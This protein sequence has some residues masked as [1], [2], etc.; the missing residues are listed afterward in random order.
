MKR[1]YMTYGF[2]QHIFKIT[3]VVLL[4]AFNLMI[5]STNNTNASP[6]GEI[7]IDVNSAS[8]STDTGNGYSF[9]SSSGVLHFDE[10][11]ANMH[12]IIK[13]TNASVGPVLSIEFTEGYSPASVTIVGLLLSKGIN[14]PSDFSAD[15]SFQKYND[16]VVDLLNN[17]LTLPDGYNGKLDINGLKVASLKLPSDYSLPLTF[18]NLTVLNTL[19]YPNNYNEPI[20]IGGTFIVPQ[21]QQFP[22]NYSGAVTIGNTDGVFT[23]THVI[24]RPGTNVSPHNGIYIPNAISTITMKN[25]KN[26]N[27]SLRWLLAA[28][29]DVTLLLDGSSVI[30]GYIE[31]PTTAKITIDSASS[32]GT[33]SEIGEL[34]ITTDSSNACIGGN[35]QWDSGLIVIKGGTISAR[36]T[37]TAVGSYAAAIGGGSGKA[38]NVL[39]EGGNITAKANDY[40]AAIGGG[41]GTEGIGNVTITGGTIKATAGTN[42]AAIGGGNNANG[43]LKKSTGGII[44]ISGGTIIASGGDIALITIGNVGG[45]GAGIGSGRNGFADIYIS[46]GNVTANSGHGAGI[47]SGSNGNGTVKGFISITGGVIRGYSGDGANIGAGLNNGYIPVYKINK[48][49]DILMYGRSLN[50]NDPGSIMCNGNN[51]GDGYFVNCFN[52]QQQIRGDIYV[53]NVDT[54]LLQKVLHISYADTNYMSFL[55]S[56]GHDYPEN[57]HIYTDYYGNA[58]T[59]K[60]G[61][62]RQYTHHYD[63]K[64]PQPGPSM[65]QDNEPVI[66]SVTHMKSYPHNFHNTFSN[67]LIVCFGDDTG[68]GGTVLYKIKEKYVD[69]NG[70]PIPG[71]SDNFSIV[72]A[73]EPYTNSIPVIDGYSILGYYIGDPYTGTYIAGNTV[74]VESL[75]DDI[76]IYYVYRLR[77]KTSLQISKLVTGDYANRNK[78]FTFKVVIKDSD[79]SWLTPGITFEYIGETLPD[80]T[81]QAPD[82]GTVTIGNEGEFEISL[83]HGQSIVIDSI[84][85]DYTIQIIEDEDIRYLVTYEDNILGTGSS[86]DTGEWEM[87]D[88]YRSVI[89]INERRY[90]PETGLDLSNTDAILLLPIMILVMLY[91]T[92]TLKKYLF[93]KYFNHNT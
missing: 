57:F 61:G 79:G 48:E 68:G 62:M 41:D 80:I 42:G 58:P 71:K 39:I 21:S 64:P 1:L 6:A 82:N 46:G 73:H 78:E 36:Q 45:Y 72:K 24:C 83:K 59:Y 10:D 29:D 27:G 85:E 3:L 31:V 30:N 13:R 76:T 23:G 81:T 2:L 84:T 54:S 16:S 5:L 75:E 15:L 51:Q 92:I 65:H 8:L 32:P 12:Y 53:Y 67:G 90:V 47:G 38:G 70:N 26:L 60:Y 93:R 91:L 49:A 86:R 89:F 9:I 43:G 87:T 88:S 7:I 20:T 63:H 33:N 17:S 14:I 40:G 34:S 28:T 22:A 4:L 52:Y 77:Q 50:V 18:N 19:S 25:A 69:I 44:N 55:F 66:P 74:E 56:T 37:S 11:A 35:N